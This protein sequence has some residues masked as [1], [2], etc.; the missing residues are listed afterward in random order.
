MSW[1]RH[2]TGYLLSDYNNLLFD[3][4]KDR[5]KWLINSSIDSFKFLCQNEKIIINDK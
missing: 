1:N 5:L 3:F 2:I 4:W